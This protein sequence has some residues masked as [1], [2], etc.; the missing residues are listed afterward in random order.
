MWSIIEVVR[1][2]FYTVKQFPKLAESK[3]ATVL[4]L[5]RYNIFIPVYPTGVSGELLATYYA[6]QAIS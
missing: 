1:F 5:I 3:L 6:Y 2:S 4:G